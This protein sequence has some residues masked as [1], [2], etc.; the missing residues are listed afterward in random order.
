MSTWKNVCYTLISLVLTRPDNCLIAG[1]TE[2]KLQRRLSL[3]NGYVDDFN[4]NEGMMNLPLCSTQ[5]YSFGFDTVSQLTRGLG[6]RLAMVLGDLVIHMPYLGEQFNEEDSNWFL[7]EKDWPYWVAI[8][9][10]GHARA[11]RAY[12]PKSFKGYRNKANGGGETIENSALSYYLGS[13]KFMGAND[14]AKTLGDE[15]SVKHP[16]RLLQIYAGGLNNESRLS[17]TLADTVYQHN[18]HIAYFGPYLKGRMAAVY[19]VSQTTEDG[20]IGGIGRYYKNN[21]AGFNLDQ[22]QYG[23]WV[24]LLCSASTYMFLKGYWEFI[25]TGNPVVSTFTCKGVRLPDVSFY[26]TS[27]GLS[28]EVVTGYQWSDQL[29]FNLGVETVY[30]PEFK[31]VELTPSIRYILPTHQHGNFEFNVG[32]VINFKGNLAFR[33]S[34]EWRDPINPFALSMTLIHHNVNTYVGERNIPSAHDSNH[35]FELSINASLLY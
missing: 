3:S 1:H 16:S 13:I 24:S 19:Y 31:A 34:V 9:E 15:V 11:L 10:F 25:Q 22:I 20:D 33:G 29:W 18:G 32:S 28:L 7:K 30:Y 12:T 4:S 2:P 17:K 23:G 27:E 21:H 6:G 26:F 5:F 14:I 8:H 35:D